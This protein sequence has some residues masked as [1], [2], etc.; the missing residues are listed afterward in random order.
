MVWIS[1]TKPW[2]HSSAAN[3]Q[4]R[5]FNGSESP[6]HTRQTNPSICQN[7]GTSKSSR[8]PL[9]CVPKSPYI[10]NHP[11]KHHITFTGTLHFHFD[12]FQNLKLEPSP[13]LS[14]NYSSPLIFILFLFSPQ[15]TPTIHLLASRSLFPPL[16]HI[17]NSFFSALSSPLYSTKKKLTH[18]S[19]LKKSCS[20]RVKLLWAMKFFFRMLNAF[21]EFEL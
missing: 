14:H 15:K 16:L 6:I 1:L 10:T 7:N 9:T 11:N 18:Y 21:G 8:V 19:F 3:F 2:M 13:T 4:S 20:N 17:K 12:H 5:N